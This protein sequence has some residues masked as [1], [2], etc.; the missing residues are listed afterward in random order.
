MGRKAGTPKRGPVGEKKKKKNTI[1]AIERLA[2]GELR[3]RGRLVATRGK[4]MRGR[5]YSGGERK[6]CSVNKRAFGAWLATR[7]GKG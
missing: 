7:L 1:S 3:K 4:K 5:G 2:V 6:P